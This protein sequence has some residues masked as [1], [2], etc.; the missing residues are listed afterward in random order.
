MEENVNTTFFV[1]SYRDGDYDQIAQLWKLTDMGS[2]TRG[3]DRET[4]EDS[5]LIGGAMLILE[6]KGS[7]KVC[8]TSWM[9]FDGRRIHLHHFGILPDY[10]G[11]GLSNILLKASLKFIKA[12]GYQVKLEV[13]QSNIKAISLY[14]KWGF[15]YLGDYD[16]YIIRDIS[17]IL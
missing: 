15:E 5:I 14:K 7:G 13:H 12:K 11:K 3:D 8:G 2:P 4:I 17:E 6:E 1:R 9:T 10:Q 16:V